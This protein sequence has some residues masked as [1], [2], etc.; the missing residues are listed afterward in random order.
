MLKIWN[1]LI[2]RIYKKFKSRLFIL[3]CPFHRANNWDFECFNSNSSVNNSILCWKKM[4]WCFFPLSFK[5]LLGNIMAS[6]RDLQSYLVK[7]DNTNRKSS[8]K[9][10]LIIQS[11]SNNAVETEIQYVQQEIK[12]QVANLGKHDDNIPSKIKQE[13]GSY[14]LFHGN[15]V[16][17][18]RFRNV[19]TKHP[20]KRAMV[21]G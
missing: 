12:K 6:K 15:K 4:F 7:T 1:F 13:M 2:D 21:N 10:S 18:G 8:Q 11:S 3:H 20:P 19:Y 9:V 5:D 16:A 14:A 17:I